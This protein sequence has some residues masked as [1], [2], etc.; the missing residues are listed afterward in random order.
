MSSQIVCMQHTNY[1]MMWSHMTIRRLDTPHSYNTSKIY[2]FC[3][4]WCYTSQLNES[5][6]LLDRYDKKRQ[7]KKEENWCRNYITRK[8]HVVRRRTGTYVNLIFKM[9]YKGKL[10]N[11]CEINYIKIEIQKNS[12]QLERNDYYF[13]KIHKNYVNVHVT[14]TI[15]ITM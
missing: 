3:H 11:C 14:L 12:S 15:Y 4:Y 8:S 6:K 2:L 13:C 10:Y 1:D 5:R 9:K 7:A